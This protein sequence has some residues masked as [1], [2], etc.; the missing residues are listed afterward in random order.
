MLLIGK[1]TATVSSTDLKRK[2]K[3]IKKL[4][5]KSKIIIVT[6]RNNDD[7]NADFILFPYSETAIEKMEDLLEDIEMDKNR[8][9]LIKEFDTSYKSGKGKRYTLKDI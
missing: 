1:N 4:S 6:N 9:N 7:G 3:D 5:Q 2:Y 8:D